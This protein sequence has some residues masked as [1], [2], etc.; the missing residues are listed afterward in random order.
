VCNGPDDVRINFV[1][2]TFARYCLAF[3]NHSL[4]F[5]YLHSVNYITIIPHAFTNYR[6]LRMQDQCMCL[7]PNAV[8]IHH[9]NARWAWA[10]KCENYSFIKAFFFFPA[11]T[12]MISLL[13][14]IFHARAQQ[15]LF[16]VPQ[17]IPSSRVI[18]RHFYYLSC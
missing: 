7:E 10:L 18:N 2:Y 5:I 13:F 17:A 9:W 16:H 11:T 3:Y 8:S 14:A 1:H 12:Y 4:E 6:L 15:Y